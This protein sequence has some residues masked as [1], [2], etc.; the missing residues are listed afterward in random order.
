MGILGHNDTEG[1]AVAAAYMTWIRKRF[2]GDLV[3][4]SVISSQES[5]DRITGITLIQKNKKTR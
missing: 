4:R 1:A 3:Q 5:G 2:S